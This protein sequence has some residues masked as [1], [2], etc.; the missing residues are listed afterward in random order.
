MTRPFWPT[1]VTTLLLAVLIG[2][3]SWQVRRLQW[4]ENLIATMEQR[5]A[6]AP[7][8]LASLSFANEVNYRRVSVSGRFLPDRVFY[9]FAIARSGEG[10]YHLL[11]PLQLGD[12]RFLLVDR[13]WIPYDRRGLVVAPVGAVTLSGVLRQPEHHW[14]QPANDAVGNNWYGVDLPKMAELATVPDFLPTV[15]ELDA[16]PNPGGYPLGGQTRVSL[17]ND[18]LGYAMTWYGLAL[19]LLVIYGL[20]FRRGAN[21]TA[22]GSVDRS[23]PPDAARR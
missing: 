15:L 7:I 22:A 21:C 10:G 19:A 8:D 6:A 18:H 13:G 5:M 11:T 2:L 14:S 20:A 23:L 9:Q 16:T 12:G 4:K 3:G 17:P 1:L